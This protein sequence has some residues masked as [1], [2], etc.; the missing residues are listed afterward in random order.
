VITLPSLEPAAIRRVQKRTLWVLSLGLVLNAMGMGAAF[1]LGSLIVVSVSGSVLFAGLSAAMSTLGAAVFAI[2]LAALAARSGRR[3]ALTTGALIALIGAIFVVVAMVIGNI[4]LLLLAMLVLGTGNALSMQTRFA[5]GDLSTQQ[6]RGRDISLVVWA[7][8][9]GI[10]LGPNLAGPGDVL[11]TALGLPTLS[12]AFVFTVV[13]QILAAAIYFWGL[14]PDPLVLSKRLLHQQEKDAGITPP[15]ASAS[16]RTSFKLIITRPQ[17]AVAVFV[18][19]MSHATMVSI[20]AMTPVHLS[21]MNIA[22]VLIGLTVSL[23]TAGMY[24][25]SPVFG[26]L[27]DR[28]GLVPVILAG[29]V[30]FMGTIILN[31]FWPENL[32]SVMVA[33][34]LLGLGWSAATVAGSVML[35]GALNADER[36]R[37]Q[38]VSDSLMSLAGAGGGA[39]AG[40]ILAALGY[41]MLN[42]IVLW[43]VLAVIIVVLVLGWRKKAAV[44]A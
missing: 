19:I 1:S 35:T 43:L 40:V 26:W 21:M 2:P 33:L 27:S 15:K 8:T 42:V 36:P 44:T 4:W 14:R 20:M 31:W 29:Q 11:G 32:G 38:G 3:P 5:A 28:I 10:V 9:I 24:A 37:V 25:L 30:M 39:L 13:A 16:F 7:T 6:T 22:V 23:H 17:A 12:G 41:P 34:I 18:M